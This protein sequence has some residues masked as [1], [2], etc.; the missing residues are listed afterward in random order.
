MPAERTKRA[1]QFPRHQRWRV[2]RRNRHLYLG[3]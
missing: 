3:I 1:Q 2:E